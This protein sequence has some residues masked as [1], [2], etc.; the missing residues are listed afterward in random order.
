MQVATLKHLDIVD[1]HFWEEEKLNARGQMYPCKMSLNV[2][3]YR[4]TYWQFFFFSR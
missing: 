2:S 4:A 3:G 1:G